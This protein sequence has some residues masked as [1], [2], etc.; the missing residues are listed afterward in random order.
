[1][2]DEQL[3][4]QGTRSRRPELRRRPPRYTMDR[5]SRVTLEVMEKQ[6]DG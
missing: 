1:M 3:Y 4:G 2:L 6:A 5:S